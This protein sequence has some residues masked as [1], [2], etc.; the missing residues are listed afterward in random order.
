[1]AIVR[2]GGP[3]NLVSLGVIVDPAAITIMACVLIGTVLLAP[4]LLAR[5]RAAQEHGLTPVFE[6]FCGA[7]F[8]SFGG[9]NIPMYRI[10]IYKSFVVIAFVT[11]RVI[12]FAEIARAEVFSGV[13]GRDIRI[14]LKSGVKF[15]LS[16]RNPEDVVRLLP[17]A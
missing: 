8:G 17:H 9:T 6:T 10:L 1:L 11:P 15:H 2:G 7:R 14:V 5:R 4:M 3:V 16:V 13:F 12:P